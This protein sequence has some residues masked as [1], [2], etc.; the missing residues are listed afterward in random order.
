MELDP[1]RQQEIESVF[2][3]LGIAPGE[4]RSELVAAEGTSPK[5]IFEVVTSNTSQPFK[6]A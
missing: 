1:A 5:V 3:A 6:R 4:Q 2:D